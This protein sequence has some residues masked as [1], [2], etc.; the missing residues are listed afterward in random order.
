[1]KHTTNSLKSIFA[2][3]TLFL[4]KSGKRRINP[5]FGTTSEK[6]RLSRLMLGYSMEYTMYRLQAS[7]LLGI[8]WWP[9][10]NVA[11]PKNMNVRTSSA[12]SLRS[13]LKH[14]MIWVHLSTSSAYSNKDKNPSLEPSGRRHDGTWMYSRCCHNTVSQDTSVFSVSRSRNVKRRDGCCPAASNNSF[15]VTI[16]L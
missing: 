10:G 3:K 5:S 7:V 15:S 6:V 13:F 14:T 4:V 11:K 8:S 2:H 1:M 9:G 12:L 16:L